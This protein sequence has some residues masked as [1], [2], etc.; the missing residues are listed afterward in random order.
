MAEITIRRSRKFLRFAAGA[1]GALAL[2]AAMRALAQEQTFPP[3]ERTIQSPADPATSRSIRLGG[4]VA[5][6]NLLSQ[7]TPVYPPIAKTAHISGTVLLHCIISKD[8]TVQTL[9]YVSG[10][11]LLMKAAL[12][13]VRQ[14]KY[15][16]ML[17]NNAPVEVD[18]TV[19]VVFTLGG[20]AAEAS[21]AA[22]SATIGRYTARGYVNDYAGMIDSQYQ[23]QLDQICRDLDQKTRTQ[24]AI[25]TVA[26]LE[27]LSA[28]EFAT[29]LANHWGV[30]HKDTNRG[31]L[32]LL[33]D[34][35]RQYRIA[36]GRGLESVI[37][38]DEADRLGKEML[39]MLREADYGGA[40]LHLAAALQD[41][42]QRKVR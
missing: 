32:I 1:A 39:P 2:F 27:G 12:D 40:L 17:V 36:I 10:P 29:R 4:H 30:G 34:T 3:P 7:V 31:I 35:D 25:V 21:E 22:K 9:E 18:T 6:A 15:K 16:P 20:P 19:S 23:A 11:P 28:K 33:T 41:E 42:V 37:T 38:D 24:M 13:A 5:Q 26:S 14:W 8:G